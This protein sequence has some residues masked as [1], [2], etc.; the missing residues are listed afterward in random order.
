MLSLAIRMNVRESYTFNH[1]F[2]S[3]F[4][5]RFSSVSKQAIE[6]LVKSSSALVFLALAGQML[7]VYFKPSHRTVFSKRAWSKGVKTPL[8]EEI[9]FRLIPHLLIY[10]MQWGYHRLRK[11]GEL[12]E[13]QKKWELIS[14]V[15]L[16]ALIF[17]ISHL[18]R[19]PK[20]NLH[21]QGPLTFLGGLIY[22]GLL[23]KY[24]TLSLGILFHGINNTIAATAAIYPTAVYPFV[25]YGLNRCLEIYA[26][27]RNK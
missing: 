21:I 5:P 17:S 4:W 18:I 10:A 27:C 13:N 12:T 16:S 9:C 15:V 23:E 6:E 19:N 2:S 20:T 7:V 3:S 1:C 26:L 25:A 14:R 24:H 8:R 22:G 11:D